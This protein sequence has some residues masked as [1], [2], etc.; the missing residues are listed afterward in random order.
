[1]I[2]TCTI[3]VSHKTKEAV[4]SLIAK[5]I[6]HGTKTHAKFATSVL[7]T[8]V[9]TCYAFVASFMCFNLSS[10][11]I[12]KEAFL[13]AVG[14]ELNI[15]IVE[16]NTQSNQLPVN[17]EDYVNCS[18]SLSNCKNP[19]N[20]FSVE[21]A[22]NYGDENCVGIRL[23]GNSTKGAKKRPY[24]IKFDEK[25]SVMGLKEN[26]S[27]VLLADYFDQSYIRNYT[28][29]TLANE[30][31]NLDGMDD[32]F[33]PTPYHVALII[34]DEFKGLYLLC[35]QMDENKGRAAV[36]KDFDIATDKEFPFLV[37]MDIYAYKEGKTGVDNF[38]VES[39][40]NHA[41]IK[42]PEAEERYATE[43]SDVVYDYINEYI[44][45]V[46]KTLTTNEK[47]EVSFRD[48]PVGLTDLVDISS[49]VDHYLINEIML[50]ADAT[51]KS[52]YFHKTKNG[53]M[54][55]GPIWD[56]DFSMGTEFK[57]PYERSYIEQANYMHM[58]KNSAIFSSL[59]KNESF[60][61]DV[62]ARYNTINSCIP[63]VIN[64]LKSYK[65]TIKNVALLDAKMWHGNNG[66]FQYDM[67]Y[68]YVR[69]FLSDRHEALNTAFSKTHA[70]F[71]AN[72]IA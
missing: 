12:S 37:E 31:D 1:M 6:H 2:L 14:N 23:R 18:F 47:V 50:N 38:P 26:K 7:L 41:E 49:A 4:E 60:Y 22:G 40:Y 66:E 19:E 51:Q 24:R 71:M 61:T 44:N 30:I 57:L 35:E 63:N 36:K 3:L 69:L 59:M 58:A 55:F 64:H 70:E 10:H 33:S 20:N 62:V 21:M 11:K 46:F 39:V 45:A 17:K 5:K 29:F 27:W 67:Q 28:A 53:L 34:N 68:D 25:Q 13:N 72:Y 9:L 15:P 54:K 52:I 65:S 56:F 32:T 48:T 43:T 8:V 42:Y 16:I